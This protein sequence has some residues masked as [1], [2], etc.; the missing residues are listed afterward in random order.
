LLRFLIAGRRLAGGPQGGEGEAR[1]GR[2]PDPRTRPGRLN[3][4]HPGLDARIHRRRTRGSSLRAG[5][6]MDARIKAAPSGVTGWR[7][8]PDR[9]DLEL[10]RDLADRTTTITGSSTHSAAAL[11]GAN[12]RAARAASPPAP[13]PRRGPSS[14]QRH[15]AVAA[16][17]RLP[18]RTGSRPPGLLT[19]NLTC[20]PLLATRSLRCRRARRRGGRGS[21]RLP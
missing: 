15:A 20:S 5:S 12:A 8:W 14:W 7:V 2:G 10:P 11:L 19:S 3:R 13:R 21:R 4:V 6:G 16:R 17:L 18:R 1:H 9:S